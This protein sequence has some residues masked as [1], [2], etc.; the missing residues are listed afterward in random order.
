MKQTWTT[1]F[2]ASAICPMGHSVANYGQFND[3]NVKKES[4]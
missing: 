1:T 2:I 3:Y 4:V